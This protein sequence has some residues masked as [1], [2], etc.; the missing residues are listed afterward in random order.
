MCVNVSVFVLRV[1][2]YNKISSQRITRFLLSRN[3]LLE[4]TQPSL[5]EKYL[6]AHLSETLRNWLMPVTSHLY[7]DPD[8][9][10][11]E[12]DYCSFKPYA[13]IWGSIRFLIL[14]KLCILSSIWKTFWF[15][16][17]LVKKLW[18]CEFS[19]ILGEFSCEFSKFWNSVHRRFLRGLGQVCWLS[20]LFCGVCSL[21]S[22]VPRLSPWG[23]RSKEKSPL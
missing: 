15:L 3:F 10:D 17:T 18:L 6:M 2:F 16:I 5:P 8:L 23:R 11:H 22:L 21:H 14:T 20:H 9:L 1:I 7:Y 19:I 12:R 13:R 4:I